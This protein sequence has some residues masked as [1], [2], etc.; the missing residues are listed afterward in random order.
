MGDRNPWVES[1]SSSYIEISLYKS[2]KFIRVK[3]KLKK[4]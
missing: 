3:K 1:F 4:N 2:L